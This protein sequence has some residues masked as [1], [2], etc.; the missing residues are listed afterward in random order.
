MF[1]AG[2]SPGCGVALDGEEVLGPPGH[3]VEGAA[4]VAG[5]DLA[6]GGGGLGEGAI[7]GEGDDEVK[8]GVQAL[9]AGEIHFC[10]RGRGDSAGAEEF[11]LFASG[12]EGE[13][14]EG[15][16]AGGVLLEDDVR[17]GAYSERL[18]RGV[19][20]HARGHGVEDKGGSGG[21]LQI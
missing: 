19:E 20:R 12:E 14:F 15:C 17:G 8:L 7:F 16:V 1:E 2:G 3:A 4:V 5:G 11:G 10:Q 9:E 18:L 6:V 13:S 21:V